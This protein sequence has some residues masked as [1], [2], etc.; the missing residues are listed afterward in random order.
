[1]SGSGQYVSWGRFPFQQQKGTDL[2][3]RFQV[4]LPTAEAFLPQ[5]N[6]R[7]YGDS[8][9]LKD[10]PVLST[11]HLDKFIA[12]DAESGRIRCEAGVQLIDILRVAEPQGWFLAVTP[13]TQFAT[14]AGCIAN[15]VHGKNH[16]LTGSFG[17]H[18]TGFELLRSS[19]ERLFCSPQENA[20][21]FYA[22]VGGLG[23]TGVILWAEIQLK[24]TANSAI[25]VETIKYE[26]LADFFSLSEDSVES[27]EYSVAWI[28]C[29]ASG[30][31][32]GRGHFIRGNHATAAQPRPYF[33]GNKM[34]FPVQPP[35]S[36]VN[37]LSLRAFNS[38]Y[39]HRQRQQ[40]AFATVH[41]D[42]FFYPLDGINHWNRM[43]GPKGFLQYQCVV[44]PGDSEH[45]V[46]EIL[47]RIAA[48]G[49]GSFLAVLKVFGDIESLGM[50]S[51]PRPG[52]TLALDFPYQGDKTM[53]LFDQ[54][55][56][57]VVGAKGAIYPAKDAHIQAEHF[58]TFF[59][60][61]DQFLPF[62][63]P[64]ISSSFWQRVMG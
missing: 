28:D 25:N 39:Y 13:G 2:S 37:S 52:T 51:F 64:K 6:A 27:H 48:A 17:H 45:A 19:G 20:D 58:T 30:D 18:V 38:L 26:R 36:L 15:D 61:V 31:K 11:R 21:W 10:G 57:I 1:M 3:Q 41:Y 56:D 14:V 47:H 32:L 50:L 62:K 4:E 59:P 40:R 9:M 23:L 33:S 63:D 8:C 43:Y 34:A 24:A 29:L 42:P 60:K 35:I 44:P 12:F 46:R 53:D 54:L 16:H 5:G 49:V 7:S 22:T 55:D